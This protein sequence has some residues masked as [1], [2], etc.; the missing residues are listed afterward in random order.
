M[1]DRNQIKTTSSIEER[2]KLLKLLKP[3]DSLLFLDDGRREYFY[4]LEIQGDQIKGDYFDS[5]GRLRE[6]TFSLHR[7]A[8]LNPRVAHYQ[9]I[10]GQ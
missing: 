8:E 7:L 9:E 5:S 3:N 6:M 2:V 4:I 1:I 10:L